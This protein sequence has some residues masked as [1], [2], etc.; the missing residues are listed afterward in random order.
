MSW[1]ANRFP[2]LAKHGAVLRESWR[3]Q[4]AADKAFK[5]T[6]DH[7]FLPAALEI[8]EK[9]PSVGLRWLL[10]LLCA[11]FV[12]ALVWSIIGKVDV[13]A[14]AGGKTKPTGAA[15]VIQPIEI[16]SV[17]K[18]YVKNGQYVRKGQLLIE[19]DPTLAV[20]DQAQSTQTLLTAQIIAARND[21]LLSH[22]R[23]NNARFIPPPR[24][25]QAVIANE[26]QFL[27]SAIAEYEAERSALRQQR[28]ERSAELAGSSAEIAKLT[29][30]IPYL[31]RQMAARIELTEKG[32]FSK[33]RL[34]EFEQARGEH[35]R[36][37]DVQIA[38]ADRAR[39]AIGNIDAQLN[40]LRASFGKTAMT[41]LAEASGQAALAGE[42]LNKSEKRREFQELR[43]PVD[44]VVQQ[45]S[46]STVGGVVQPAQSL[47]VI[48]PCASAAGPNPDPAACTSAVEV[49]AFVQNKDIGFIK[50][51][52]KVAVKLEAFNFTDFG[53][54]EGTVDFISRDAV[55]L[56][57]DPAGSQQD[58]RGRP[59]QQ[60][61]V[62]IARIRLECAPTRRTRAPLCDRVQPGMSVQAEIKTGQRRIIQYLLSPISKAMD[63]AGR[64]R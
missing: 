21:A 11:L 13:V 49:E 54:I 29:E 48:V 8:M 59:A 17:R 27:Q 1:F 55:D 16:G 37:I 63:E 31:D 20:A 40:R 53:L 58:A 10:R 62:Y 24:T 32:Y 26:Q 12:I 7:E 61:L 51:G 2:T 36:N 52:Q 18:I 44:G 45:L 64:E 47:M 4:G 34:L 15:K 28:A 41:D 33:L 5:P 14:T 35:M 56:S 39:A 50:T 43:S 3:Q 30:A 6:S 23:G 38:N 57:Q 60:G 19:L 42:E 22:L 25:P 9:P 46:I